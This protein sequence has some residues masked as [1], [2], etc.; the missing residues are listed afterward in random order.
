G[1]LGWRHVALLR[2]RGHEVTP[3][4]RPGHRPR[5]A[6][7]DLD[8]VE[9]DVGSSEARDLVAGHDAVLHF[10]GVPDPAGAARDPT[11]AVREN[12]GTTLNLLDGCAEHGAVLVYP[13]SARAGIEPSPDAYAMSKRL[14]EEACRLHAARAV[15]LR[16]T[17]VFGPGQVAWEGATGAIAAFAARALDGR[18]IAIPGNPQ[19]TRDFLYVDDLV[20]GVERLVAG[21]AAERP[22]DDALLYAGSGVATPLVDAARLA[23]DAAGADVE[24][25]LPGGELPPGEDESYALEPGV[26]RLELTPRPLREAVAAYV[27]WLR[28]HPERPAAQGRA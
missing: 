13:S 28:L 12:A 16:L 23:L 6:A 1:Y 5:A 15:V 4:A 17:S 26:P 18:P 24:V 10:A 11:R 19:R 2:E 9:L 7:R 14:G 22:A 20:D 3:L 27:D 21:A 25:A 8:P